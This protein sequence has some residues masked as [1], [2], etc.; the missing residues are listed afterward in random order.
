MSLA[1]SLIELEQRRKD[2][3]SLDLDLFMN[4]WK[5]SFASD[6]DARKFW[7]LQ[8]EKEKE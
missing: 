5:E 4:K 6:F 8:N 3:Q 2:A 1:P 7:F